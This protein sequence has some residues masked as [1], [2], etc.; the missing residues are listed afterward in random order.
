M[1]HQRESKLD[2]QWRACA[3]C[4]GQGRIITQSG[5]LSMLEI[6]PKCLGVREDLVAPRG[7]APR[8]RS[9]R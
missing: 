4:W 1:I 8:E 3:W 6:C 2:G 7:S 9:G 5:S